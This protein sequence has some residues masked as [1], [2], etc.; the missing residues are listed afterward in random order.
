M[1]TKVKT[2]VKAIPK[3]DTVGITGLSKDDASDKLFE[4]GYR[5]KAIKEYWKLYGKAI[6]GGI[7]QA[8]LDWLAESDRTQFDLA[9]FVIEQG[10]PNEARWFGQR[11]AIR[12]L[13]VKARNTKG[14]TD[15]AYSDTQK[16][17]MKQIVASVGK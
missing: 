15:K 12:R 1:N 3:T 17:K 2:E 6:K 7:F 11:D 16:E 8:T 4:A 13:S 10:T 5:S 9:Q 14:F